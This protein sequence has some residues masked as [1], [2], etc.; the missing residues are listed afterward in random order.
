MSTYCYSSESVEFKYR[1]L[2][3]GYPIVDEVSKT[4]LCFFE[5]KKLFPP[6]VLL[7]DNLYG[8][9]FTGDI[10]NQ[11][12]FPYGT[13]RLDF[14]NHGGGI[15]LPVVAEMRVPYRRIP[16]YKVNTIDDAQRLFAEI[17]LANSDY[18]VLLRGQNKVYQ[19]ERKDGEKMFFYG[20]EDVVEPSFMPSFSRKRLDESMIVN[21]WHNLADMLVSKLKKKG[22]F[23]PPRLFELEMFHLFA[24]GIAQHYGLPSVG[25]D[26]TDNLLTALWFA[27]HKVDYSPTHPVEAKLINEDDD[28]IIFIFRCSPQSVF[29]Y[30]QL[31]VE[32][33]NERPK[34]QNAYFNHCGW[35]QAKNQLALNL[36]AAIRVDASFA[37]Y[38][39]SDYT[40]YLFPDRKEDD[41]LDILLDIKDRFNGS[42]FGTLMESIYV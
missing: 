23:I 25:L 38:L 3:N 21:S 30:R 2:F 40:R 5:E 28:A 39:P 33:G 17:S 1:C 4:W 37:Q 15:S 34:R 13:D 8:R 7:S 19:V 41:V 11:G 10:L 14:Y 27:L 24:L 42:H 29:S 22:Y 20:S 35:G 12:C 31:G 6:D 32:I 9:F 16:V 18:K 36:A 26:L